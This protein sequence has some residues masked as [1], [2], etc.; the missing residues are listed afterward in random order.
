M[1]LFLISPGGTKSQ[2]LK[3]RPHDMSPSGFQV[4]FV[5][6]EA[7]LKGGGNTPLGIL[8]TNLHLSTFPSTSV[9]HPPKIAKVPKLKSNTSLTI[10]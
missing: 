6:S 7:C 2:L 9:V 8:S 1:Q 3:R 10:E 5:V 4:S